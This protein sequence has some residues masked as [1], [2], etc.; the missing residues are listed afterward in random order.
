MIQ[1]SFRIREDLS[2][3]ASGNRTTINFYDAKVAGQYQLSE[4]FAF[5]GNMIVGMEREEANTA[6]NLVERNSDRLSWEIEPGIR[7]KSSANTQM[8]LNYFNAGKRSDK[9]E[10]WGYLMTRKPTG[11][12][13]L[14]L[15]YANWSGVNTLCTL[16][17]GLW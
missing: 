16:L 7:F 12:F 6:S 11:T 5:V 9:G 4:R 2:T 1:P 3:Y 15:E 17:L 8:T 10:T 13:L 14:Q